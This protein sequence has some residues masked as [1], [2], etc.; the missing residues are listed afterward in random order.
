MRAVP[1]HGGQ[2]RMLR[3]SVDQSHQVVLAFSS[4][5]SLAF[6]SAQALQLSGVL[7][8]ALSAL[9]PTLMEGDLS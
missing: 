4:D 9:L 1:E 5:E 3:L 7:A 8:S 2:A 6:T